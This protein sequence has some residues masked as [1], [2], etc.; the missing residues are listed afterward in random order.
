MIDNRTPFR[1]VQ[2]YFARFPTPK[3]QAQPRPSAGLAGQ[4]GFR[5]EVTGAP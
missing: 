2:L 4:R 1:E 3:S 5:W